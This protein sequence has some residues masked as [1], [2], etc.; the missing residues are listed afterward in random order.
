MIPSNYT[1]WKIKRL[2][3][4]CHFQQ[5]LRCDL[6]I[7]PDRKVSFHLS[8]ISNFCHSPNK[9]IPRQNQPIYAF[10]HAD[11]SK[12]HSCHPQ[13]KTNRIVSNIHQI[14]LNHFHI[15]SRAEIGCTC[16]KQ[17]AR[18]F[19]L[20]TN[21]CVKH[22]AGPFNEQNYGKSSASVQMVLN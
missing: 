6:Y 22:P 5:S 14:K 9:K 16:R 18:S 12:N 20:A 2:F 10:S 13:Q 3:Q 15:F 17:K 21:G 1:H 8:S 11:I 4:K 19:G 7:I